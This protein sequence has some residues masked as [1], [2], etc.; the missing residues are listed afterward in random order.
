MKVKENDEL[1]Y[2]STVNGVSLHA[3]VDSGA[4]Q[5]SMSSSPAE[6]CSLQVQ[7]AD[8]LPVELA[9]GGL[10]SFLHWK[11]GCQDHYERME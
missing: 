11:N 7:G 6:N 1:V 8:D 5:V 4:S 3:L 9:N 10:A 2:P